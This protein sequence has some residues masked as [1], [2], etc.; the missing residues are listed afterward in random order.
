MIKKEIFGSS[1]AALKMAEIDSA[2]GFCFTEAAAGKDELLYFADVCSGPG[3]FSEYVLWRKK[4]RA[5]G[6]GYTLIGGLDFKLPAFIM[7]APCDT[8]YPYYGTDGRGDIYVSASLREFQQV[9]S[10]QTNGKMLH[11]LSGDGGADYSVD[12][13]SQEV[14]L[15]QL[16]LCQTI[17]GMLTL[18]KGGG[19]ICK[20]FDNF[21]EFT[22]GLIYLIYRHFDEVSIFK[23]NTSRQ[24]NSERFIVAKGLKRENPPVAQYLLQVNDRLNAMKDPENKTNL[25]MTLTDMTEDVVGVVPREVLTADVAFLTYMTRSI[26]DLGWTQI[27]ALKKLHNFIKDPTLPGEDQSVIRAESIQEWK[28]PDRIDRDPVMRAQNPAEIFAYLQGGSIVASEYKERFISDHYVRGP[29][30]IMSRTADWIAIMTANNPLV[31]LMSMPNR[32]CF[33]YS[34]ETLQ[35]HYV[36]G[37]MLP[38]LTFLLCEEVEEKVGSN[39][40]GVFHVVDA[41]YLGHED[42]R[43]EHYCKRVNLIELFL[44]SMQRDRRV[45][46][47]PWDHQP[48]TLRPPKLIKL[49]KV[50]MENMCKDVDTNGY[51]TGAAVL[52][53]PGK[54][55]EST[56]SRRRDGIAAAIATEDANNGVGPGTDPSEVVEAKW[57][58]IGAYFVRLLRS[59]TP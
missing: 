14:I 37:L 27:A 4:W 57:S 30:A 33:Q 24:A 35:W 19:F 54:V 59:L 40:R 17:A 6:F 58:T 44:H 49:T 32:V 2:C 43:K 41:M 15:K 1:R 12:Q 53:H 26:N 28:I 11:F 18:R 29:K 13:N 56:G 38:P 39:Y 21:T 20:C 22:V 5:K 34:F 42:I 23:P 10:E 9:V 8:F 36:A 31:Y 51:T 55:S 50:E 45:E 25:K 3:G 47:A 48:R 52:N 16:L 46:P 7:E